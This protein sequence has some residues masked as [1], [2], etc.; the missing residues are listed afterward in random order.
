MTRHLFLD[1]VRDPPELDGEV[2][3][4][5]SADEATVQ[6]DGGGTWESV[7][8][9]HHLGGGTTG[10]AVVEHMTGLADA[11]TPVDV[12]TVVTHSSDPSAADAM[13]QRLE[14]AGYQVVRRQA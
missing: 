9:D 11:G 7:W 12:G 1:D 4:V 13:R 14:A 6:L 8:L 3:V 5:R 10:M 2:V